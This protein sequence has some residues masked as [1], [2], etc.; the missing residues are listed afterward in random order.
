MEGAA[1]GLLQLR[2]ADRPA[3]GCVVGAA[4]GAAAAALDGDQGHHV[5]AA[6]TARAPRGAA[7]RHRA[8]KGDGMYVADRADGA[9]DQ[10]VSS[11]KARVG[12]AGSVLAGFSDRAPVG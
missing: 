9:D 11:K 8:A 7:K 4:A 1:A 10:P 2:G 12:Q 6:A 5:G 3:E